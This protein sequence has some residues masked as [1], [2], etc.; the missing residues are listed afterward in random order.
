MENSNKKPD[1]TNNKNHKNNNSITNENKNNNKKEKTTTNTENKDQD[2]DMKDQHENEEFNSA[3]GLEDMFPEP[4][5]HS[6]T[7]QILPCGERPQIELTLHL[8]TKVNPNICNITE[9]EVSIANVWIN[10]CGEM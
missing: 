6:K 1:P 5:K 8:S 9:T 10:F 4:E 3:P 7:T 2:T